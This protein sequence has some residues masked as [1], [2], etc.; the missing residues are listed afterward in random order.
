[1]LKVGQTKLLS[2]LTDNKLFLNYTSDSLVVE[3]TPKK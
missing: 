3:N 2:F 1:M